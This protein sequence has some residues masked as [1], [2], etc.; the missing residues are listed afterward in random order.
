MIEDTDVQLEEVLGRIG[1]KRTE[2]LNPNFY[3][4]SKYNGDNKQNIVDNYIIIGN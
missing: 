1:T 4:F 2:E 3:Y